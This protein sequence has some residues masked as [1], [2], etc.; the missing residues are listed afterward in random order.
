MFSLDLTAELPEWTAYAQMP[1][2]PLNQQP[3]LDFID[4]TTSPQDCLITDYAQLLFWSNRLPPPE[5][6]EVTSNRLRSGVLTSS[7]LIALN[8][9]Y[10][11]P[12]VAPLT[13]RLERSTPD[14]LDWVK[15]HYYGRFLYD[16]DSKVIYFGYPLAREV[17]QQS[18]IS[19]NRNFGRLEPEIELVAVKPLPLTVQAGNKVPVTLFWQLHQSPTVE[20]T[21]FVQLR[22]S[23]NAAIASADHQPYSSL[24]PFS[25]WPVGKIMPETTWLQLPA[26]LPEGDYSLF[27]GLYNPQTLERL[28]LFNDQSGENALK[29]ITMKVKP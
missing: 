7:E 23:Q 12:L 19:Y 8:E 26:D 11:C 2:T 13:G 24:L 21:V 6:S 1:D 29:L 16:E 3:L 17:V 10:A 5:L 28:S 27:I 15:A 9:A 25:H 18:T 22:N 4:E 14:Y 20:Y